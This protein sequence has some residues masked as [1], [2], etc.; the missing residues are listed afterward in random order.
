LAVAF[1]RMLRHLTDAQRNPFGQRQPRR[2]VDELAQATCVYELNML[3]SDFWP[4]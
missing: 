2:K 1:N 4:R 3:K